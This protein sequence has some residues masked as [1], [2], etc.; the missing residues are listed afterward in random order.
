MKL[1]ADEQETIV[2]LLKQ[3]PDRP[4]PAEEI[5][6]KTGISLSALDNVIAAL[7]HKGYVIKGELGLTLAGLPDILY[8][9]EIRE[10]L[11][12]D[13]LGRHI[14]H[15]MSIDSTNRRALEWAGEGA[16]EGS[17]VIA[18]QQVKGRGRFNRNWV[19][20]ASRG[21]YLTIILRPRFNM[22]L[23]SQLTLLTGV[24]VAEAM[25]RLSGCEAALKWPNDVLI[26]GKKACGILAEVRS[27]N[28]ECPDYV[29]IGIGM[30]ANLCPDDFPED[31]R[32]SSTSLLME[33]GKQVS[34]CRLLQ[35]FLVVFENHYKN[36]QDKGYDYLKK[37]W[38]ENNCTIGHKVAIKAGPGQIITG[39]AVDLSPS[40]GLLIRNEH[41][42]QEYLA[43]DVS[44]GS[45][46]FQ[47]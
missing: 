44:I 40:G 42:V 46:N 14:E 19:S 43:G 13:F 21:V 20:S 36:Y 3:S 25:R 47:N 39:E 29:V 35:D 18:E 37:I 16:E 41:G 31:C 5:A 6:I 24:A 2:N 22:S 23:T 33:T 27:K 17:V 11:K 12:T 45:N 7:I 9:W 10:N 4:L 38:L 34:R 8:P 32:S 28:T 26:K 30:N 15:Y 1:I